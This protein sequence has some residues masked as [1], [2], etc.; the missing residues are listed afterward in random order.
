MFSNGRIVA[1]AG[2]I[3][4]SRVN[5]KNMLRY[6]RKWNWAGFEGS[7]ACVKWNFKDLANLDVAIRLARSRKVVVQAGGNLGLFPKRLAEEFKIVYTYEP[8][9]ILFAHLKANAPEKRIVAQQAALGCSRESVRM[10][11]CRRDGSGRPVHEGL[12]H[13]SGSGDIPQV[14]IDDLNL[15]ECGLIYLDIE[16][17]ELNALRGAERTIRR[18]RPVLAFE[19]NSNIAHYQSS[20]QELRDWVSQL[21]YKKKLRQSGDDIYV[22]V[23]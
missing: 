1:R 16:G 22:P 7:P 17:Y 14:M 23:R 20:K 3:V 21:G 9:P 19:V 10:S 13:V 8:D 2:V 15:G 5:L 12:T 11:C 18:C 4:M 6:R